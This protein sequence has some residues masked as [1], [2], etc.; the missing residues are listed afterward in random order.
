MQVKDRMEGV[1]L[2]IVNVQTAHAFMSDPR[3][4]NKPIEM[5]M[6]AIDSKSNKKPDSTS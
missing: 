3:Q 6:M 5:K 4:S 1:I 2:I